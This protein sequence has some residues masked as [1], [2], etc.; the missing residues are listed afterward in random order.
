MEIEETITEE[1]M[2]MRIYEAENVQMFKEEEDLEQ[3]YNYIVKNYGEN[4]DEAYNKLKAKE[5]L[6]D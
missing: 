2:F 5:L 3:L 4:L 6:N 1:E